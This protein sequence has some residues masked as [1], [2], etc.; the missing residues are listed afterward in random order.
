MSRGHLALD[1]GAVA[2][3]RKLPGFAMSTENIVTI[4]DAGPCLKKVSITI[5]AEKV[6]G[7]LSESIDTLAVE[8]VLPG[9]RKG[10]APRR[11]IEKRF[12]GT[13]RTEAKT[14]L[15]AEAYGKAVEEHK[16]RVVGDPTSQT[17]PEVQVEDGKALT[18]EVE[19]EV[20][21]EFTVP[22]TNG[23][24]IKKPLLEVADSLVDQEVMKL[25]VNDG[26]LEERQTPEAG[27][28]VTGHAI[29]KGPDGTE[30]YNIKGAV[31]QIPTADKNGKGMVLGVV[32]DD[33]AQQLG[34]P[35]PGQTAT[36]KTKGPENHEVEKLRGIDL[37]VTFTVERVDRI[38]QAPIADIVAKFGFDSEASLRDAIKQRLEQR[39]GT[40]QQMAMRQ[41]IADWLLT[42]VTMPLP[43]RATSAQAQRLLE[44]RRVDLMYRGVDEHKI[45]EHMADLRRASADAAVRELKLFFILNTIADQQDIGVSDAEINSRIAQMAFEQNV[46][47]EKLRQA[48]IQRNQVGMIFQQIREH[49]AM[50]AILAAAN[51]TDIAAADFEAEMIAKSKA[52]KQG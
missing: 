39:I 34:L 25:R 43:P 45:E 18:F 8:A 28:Y 19:V 41:Q 1:L 11:L 48:I 3:A 29:M 13:V 32:V 2:G 46:R 23:I 12:G 47:P 42:N 24:A 15:V 52:A 33:F 38:I 16:L 9:F 37:V 51:V 5:P 22:D 20:V 49:K 14:Q 40:E 44:R 31:V 4:T 27:D 21:P 7:K 30:H 6:H 36:I 26:T 35:K 10:R 17:L 50:D